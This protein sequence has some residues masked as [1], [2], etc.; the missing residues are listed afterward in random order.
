MNINIFSVEN[1]YIATIIHDDEEIS[2]LYQNNSKKEILYLFTDCLK[3][4]DGLNKKDYIKLNT[5]DKY[6]YNLMNEWF[7][8][9]KEK[10]WKC[11]DGHDRPFK[12]ELI[13]IDKYLTKYNWTITWNIEINK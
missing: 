4:V 5:N 12:Q 2:F 10:N 3:W 11:D 7:L 1:K 9:W 6:F 8:K 13:E